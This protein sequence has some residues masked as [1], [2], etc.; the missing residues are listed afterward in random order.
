V[1]D[2]RA[3]KVLR[4]AEG[5]AYWV[6]AAP[7][8]AR[9]P[10]ALGYRLACWRGDLLFRCQAGKRA[11]LAGNLRLVLGNELGAA[12]TQRVTRDWFRF[13]SC[14]AVDVKRLRRGARPLRRLV[15]I[16]GREHLEAA[17]AAGKGAILCCGHFGSYDS[18]FS[19]L[20]ASGFPLTIIGRRT[21]VYAAGRS[22]AERWFYELVY[23]RPLRRYR[24]RPIIEPWH[25]RPQVAVLAAAALRANEV[26]T[27]SIDA[28]P[29]DGDRARAVEVPFLG[30]PVR[31]LP[32]VVTLA[33][34][35]GAPLLT[36]FL[37]RAA[38]YRHQVWEI[39]AP[40]P[41]E[42]ETAMA[43]E[44]CAAEVSAAIQ[45]SPAHW[46]FWDST[47]SLADLGLIGPPP[48][49]HQPC[50][51]SFRQTGG[52]D[53]ADQQIAPLRERPAQQSRRG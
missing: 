26:I 25:G 44:R 18:G 46:D 48:E 27:I 11:R 45:R 50:D 4:N 31:L 53:T 37:F 51:R 1:G 34:V 43:F 15:E 52:S 32:G 10:T 24:Q 42:G 5:A 41:V 33:Q 49:G 6:A 40:V 14:E 22:S 38:D 21:Q 17:L 9:L 12:A 23:D 2:N 47:E 36:G 8:L 29:L 7:I 19:V 3:G 20:H 30:R 13:A 28:P 35:T 39:S 16:H